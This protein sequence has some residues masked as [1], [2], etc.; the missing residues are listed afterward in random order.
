MIAR[1][2]SAQTLG[3]DRVFTAKRGILLAGLAGLAAAATVTGC[4]GKALDV[5][6]DGAMMIGGSSA[7]GGAGSGA[8][9]AD[10]S[11]VGARGNLAYDGSPVAGAAWPDPAACIAAPNSPLVGSYK[12]HWPLADNYGEPK[13]DAVLTIRGLTADGQPCGTLRIGE[14]DPPPPATD[15]DAPYP[16][17]DGMDGTD[18]MG[19]KI[20]P[21]LSAASPGVEYQIYGVKNSSSRLA[22]SISYNELLRS[23]CGL[24]TRYPGSDSC[25]PGNYSASQDPNGC[26]IT[27]AGG[28]PMSISCVKLSNCLPYVC[29]CDDAGCDAAPQGTLFDLHWDDGNLEGSVNT[30][31]PI[32]LDRVP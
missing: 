21:G 6:A 26:T 25:L 13:G 10:P 30:T 29:V 14:G 22:F 2:A 7:V 17:P 19:L 8:T 15:P 11:G 16:A 20:G 1:R 9:G 18:G 12:G 32:F 28:T 27:P 4:A 24:Q 23:W 3:M 31:T 5:G